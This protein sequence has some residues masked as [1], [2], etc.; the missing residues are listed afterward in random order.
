MPA[1]TAALSRL[2]GKNIRMHVVLALNDE[3]KP[4]GSNEKKW[5]R[6]RRTQKN[7]EEREEGREDVTASGAAAK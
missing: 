5:R 6:R 2:I 1:R 4:T 3:E 7:A